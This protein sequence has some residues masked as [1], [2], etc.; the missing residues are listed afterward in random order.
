MHSDSYH[1]TCER[2]LHY[3]QCFEFRLDA[4]RGH[5]VAYSICAVAYPSTAFFQVTSAEKSD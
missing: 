5:K 4:E 1:C 3:S 2:N